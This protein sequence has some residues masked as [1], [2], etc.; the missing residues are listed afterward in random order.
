MKT[1]IWGIA[2]IA[3]IWCSSWHCLYSFSAILL[4]VM[5]TFNVFVFDIGIMYCVTLFGVSGGILASSIFL[6]Q[7]SMIESSQMV[8]TYSMFIVF[9]S[10]EYMCYYML[11]CVLLW[12]CR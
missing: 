1:G 9:L 5:K 7:Q 2:F 4:A 12:K 8:A 6:N 3:G 10:Q 11:L